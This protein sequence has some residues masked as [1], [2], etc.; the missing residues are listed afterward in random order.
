M[1]IF[2]VC[3]LDLMAGLAIGCFCYTLLAVCLRQWKNVTVTLVALDAVFTL[4][5]VLRNAIA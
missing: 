5:L 1:I 4:Y 2:T 3:T